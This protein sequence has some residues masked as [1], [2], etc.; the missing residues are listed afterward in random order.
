M[1][2]GI[3]R[4]P[5]RHPTVAWA[6]VVQA[7]PASLLLAIP[8]V[9]MIGVTGLNYR[10]IGD[11]G[12]FHIK[13]VEGFAAT[14]PRVNIANYRSASTPLS[15]LL[16]TA[17]GMLVGFEIWKLRLL[18]AIATF[19]SANVFYGICK[20]S[21]LPSPLLS[22]FTFLVFPY[23]FL[24]GFTIYPAAI[25]LFFGMSALSHYLRD[26]ATQVDLLK[27]SIL[28]GLAVLCRQSLLVIPA[29]MAI[30]ELWQSYRDGLMTGSGRVIQRLAILTIPL[31]MYAPL[32]FV[33]GGFTPAANR[34]S[35]GG[36]WFLRFTPAHLNYI[37]IL[38]GF[39][40]LPLL[41][42]SHLR[43]LPRPGVAILV[44]GA[45]VLSIFLF[46][47][48]VLDEHP[49]QIQY[50]GGLVARGLQT[51]KQAL[52]AMSAVL[53]ALALW[54]AGLAILLREATDRTGDPSRGKLASIAIIFVV[55]MIMSPFMYERYYV[56]LIPVLILML[57]R[58][59]R[60][61]RLLSM[62]AAWQALLA[63]GFSYWHIAIK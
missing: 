33:W 18:S 53:A 11:E 45:I 9:I 22:S 21:G 3:S 26:D 46:F 32:V 59:F 16:M 25:A 34:A 5:S 40:F 10:L 48:V 24:F 20:R 31:L 19:L 37:L 50:V 42:S 13:I 47:P 57:H 61:T 4:N 54:I 29:G 28:A 12:E 41:V 38:V 30:H 43:D 60:S 44:A 6:R 51:V 58:Y 39:Y 52:G 7:I 8:L 36:E 35:A 23:I 1:G 56:P 2:T 14:W 17:F 63:A 15:Y 49:G 62:W 27:G 55:L